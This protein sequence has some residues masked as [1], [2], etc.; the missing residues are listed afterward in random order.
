[1]SWNAIVRP[2]GEPPKCFWSQVPRLGRLEQRVAE[3]ISKLCRRTLILYTSSVCLSACMSI[4]LQWSI[5]RAFAASMYVAPETGPNGCACATQDRVP[6]HNPQ[7]QLSFAE[8]LAAAAIRRNLHGRCTL[9]SPQLQVYFP[10]PFI[11]GVPCSALHC[12][13]TWQKPQLQVYFAQPLNAGVLDK[14][15]HGRCTLQ[16]PRLQ[17]Y[18]P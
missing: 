1:M 8:P 11:A 5:W 4:R 15:L 3:S 12:R 10:E 2:L 9:Q 17:V 16:G 7:L 14:G 13:C 6:L 18:S